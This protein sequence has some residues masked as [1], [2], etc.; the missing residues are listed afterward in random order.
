MEPL[1]VAQ[2]GGIWI[3]EIVDRVLGLSDLCRHVKGD[4]GRAENHFPFREP[5]IRMAM[6]FSPKAKFEIARLVTFSLSQ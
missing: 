1:Y 4:K 2:E 5:W 6:D 3:A